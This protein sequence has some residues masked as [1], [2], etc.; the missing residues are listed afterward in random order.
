M[1][2]LLPVFL[3]HQHAVRLS[4]WLHCSGLFL[5]THPRYNF[6]FPSLPVMWRVAFPAF[7]SPYA[8][9]ASPPLLLLLWHPATLPSFRTF[10]CKLQGYGGHFFSVG[11]FHCLPQRWIF[12]A[13]GGW[14]H[15]VEAL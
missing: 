15:P 11:M 4:Y 2:Q 5:Q 12:T 13:M 9:T 3:P 1:T 14:Q 10:W 8:L 7:L 6:S